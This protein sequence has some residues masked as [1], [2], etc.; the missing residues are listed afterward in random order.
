MIGPPIFSRDLYS[1]AADGMMV[2]RHLSPYKFG[3]ASLGASQFLGPVSHAWLTTPSP[4]GPLFLRLANVAVRLSG[5]S[6]VSTIMFLRLLEV[7]GM[8]LIAI[9][10]PPLARAAGK[11]PARAVW[12]GVCN[13]LVLFHFEEL[14]Y[15]EIAKRLGGSLSK[16]KTDILRGR[17]ALAKALQHSGTSHETFET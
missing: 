15:D 3:P 16:V 12:L 7:A 14:S 17:E 1:Y 10:L 5:G 2:S 8:V 11:D 9:S 13:P 6:V 4:Y